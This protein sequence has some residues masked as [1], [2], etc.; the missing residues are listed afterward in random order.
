MSSNLKVNTIL[1][2]TG[3]SIGIGTADGNT[4]I[5][6]A[7]TFLSDVSV[8]GDFQVPDVIKHAGDVNTKIRF[9]A[10]DTITAET[11]GSERLR[12]TSDGKVGINQTNPKAQLDV[13]NTTAPTLD[14]NTHAGEALFLRSGGSDGDGNVQAIMAFGKSDSSSLRSGSAIASVQTDSDADKIGIGFYT[15]PSSSSSQ[16]LSQK[17]LITHDGKV[18]IGTDNPASKL[19]IAESGAS[20]NAEL[21]INYTGSGTRT[22]AIRFQ[23]GGTNFGYI[24]GGNFMLTGGAA[25]DLAIAPVSGKNLLFGIG[26]SERLRITSTGHREIRNYHYG[27]WAFVNNTTKTTITV[28]D[29]GDN[30]FTTIKLILTLIDGAYRQGMWQGEYTI[31][32]SNSVGGP[33]VNYY[34]KEHWQQVG[35][36]NWA[37][38]TVGV[39][40]TS[41]GA[42]Q[43]IADN[44]HDDANGNAYIH[45]LDVIGDIDGTTVASISS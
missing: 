44:G 3:T 36:S 5:S 11:G 7:G 21:A 8:A 16:T 4:T 45:I 22:A 10:A 37:G 35:S 6:G 34:L 40:I 26:S 13:I 23:R 24:A 25:D 15:S 1:P 29:P 17:V 43:I 38:G 27:P 33:G 14:N 32:A 30:K 42:L 9:P 12:I 2:S 18:G 19:T 41:S 31:F 39:S 20:T 28:G